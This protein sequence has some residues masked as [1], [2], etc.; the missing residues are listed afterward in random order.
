MLYTNK[1]SMSMKKLVLGLFTL[2]SLQAFSQTTVTTSTTTTTI[3]TTP[4]SNNSDKWMM[5]YNGVGVSLQGFDN[6]NARIANFPQYARL[7]DYMVTLNMGSLSQYKGFV[8]G[9]GVNLGSSLSGHE[10]K[11][12]S[13]TRFLGANIDLGYDVI[14][15]NRILLYPYVGVGWEL[16]HAKFYRDNTDVDFDDL[17][18]SPGIQNAVRPLTLSN[19]WFT[20][21]AGIGLALKS[22]KGFGVVGLK[23][24][25]TGSFTEK[26][27]KTE[28]SQMVSNAPT[29]QLRRGFV[30]LVLGHGMSA[31]KGAAMW[32]R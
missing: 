15:S 3:S 30:T 5:M 20:W 1:K 2:F 27:W 17:A 22:P 4:P 29:D 13:A 12:S 25:F 11:K 21:R 23:A 16:F 14:P 31:R 32:N 26:S 18:D 19:N 7:K 8:S 28:N 24:G 9:M 10:D 6:L